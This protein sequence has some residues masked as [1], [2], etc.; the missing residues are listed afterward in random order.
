MEHMS[1]NTS[2]MSSLS[3]METPDN[4]DAFYYYNALSQGYVNVDDVNQTM[5]PMTENAETP[6]HDN[7]TLYKPRAPVRDDAENG[8]T[9][10]VLVH[11]T[12]SSHGNSS[13]TRYKLHVRACRSSRKRKVAQPTDDLLTMGSEAVSYNDSGKRQKLD[14]DYDSQV[15]VANN[16]F[17]G[18]LP[19]SNWAFLRLSLVVGFECV[20]G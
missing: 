18:A 20:M 9:E 11:A 8:M 6:S 17:S 13:D 7:D 12:T 15:H 10:N 16:V 1:E 19:S 4:L 2:Y 3:K 5:E 14:D